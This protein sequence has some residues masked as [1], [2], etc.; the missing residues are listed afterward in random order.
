VQ[1]VHINVMVVLVHHLQNALHVQSLLYEH[2]NLIIHVLVMWD[3]MMMDLVLHANYVK[4]LVQHAQHIQFAQPV[5]LYLVNLEVFRLMIV[6]V[7]P[8]IMI[9][10]LIQCVKHAIILV[11]LVSAHLIQTVTHASLIGHIKLDLQV[12]LVKLG[13]INLLKYVILAIWHAKLASEFL[14]IVQVAI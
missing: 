4:I 7:L 3:I 9:I 14:Q 6:S 2:F 8:D 1:N 11:Q 10:W 12:V 13:F 5:F